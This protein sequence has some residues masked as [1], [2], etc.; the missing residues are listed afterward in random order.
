MNKE[1]KQLGRIDFSD[2]LNARHAHWCCLLSL[3][4]PLKERSDKGRNSYA[5]WLDSKAAKQKGLYIWL[6]VLPDGKRFRF[7]HVGLSKKGASTLASRTREHCRNAFAKD[8]TYLLSVQGDGFGCL[9]RIP[10]RDCDAK[11][12]NPDAAKRF[13][14]RIRVLLMIPPCGEHE[15][16]IA[17]MEG[18]IAHAAALALGEIQ[19]TNTMDRVQPLQD[20]AKLR[21]LVKRL[22]AVV[23]MLPEVNQ[24]SPHSAPCGQSG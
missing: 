17:C 15:E 23:P 2:F 13:L 11:G 3:G 16:A 21:H 9:E 10:Q 5:E 22:N 20:C 14:D 8:P 6:H 1:F 7:I 24:N 18:L 19:I 12:V 4:S